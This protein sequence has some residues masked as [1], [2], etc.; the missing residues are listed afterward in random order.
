MVIVNDS[1]MIWQDEH[2][3]VPLSLAISFSIPLLSFSLLMLT[4]VTIFCAITTRQN[5][6]VLAKFINDRKVY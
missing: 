2:D 5:N 4:F 3:L 6:K 1:N